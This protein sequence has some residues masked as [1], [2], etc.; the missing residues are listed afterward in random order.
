MVLDSDEPAEMTSAL[1]QGRVLSDTDPV[2]MAEMYT[3]VAARPTC[4]PD[5]LKLVLVGLSTSVTSARQRR[6]VCPGA[7]PVANTT[8]TQ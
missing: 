8:S 6:T 7:Y 5:K 3:P 1:G 4:H 2:H